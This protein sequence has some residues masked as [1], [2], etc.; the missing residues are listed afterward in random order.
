MLR[1]RK[2]SSDHVCAACTRKIRIA[3]TSNTLMDFVR[4]GFKHQTGNLHVDISSGLVLESHR[5]RIKRISKSPAESPNSSAPSKLKGSDSINSKAG[6]SIV[7]FDSLFFCF[8][9]FW[10]LLFKQSSAEA[11]T[12]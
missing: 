6:R 5:D 9:S 2:K 12:T 4:S 11:K 3:V 10:K 7:E 1:K 8:S